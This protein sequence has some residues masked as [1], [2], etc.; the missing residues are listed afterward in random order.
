MRL[1]ARIA[2]Q[3]CLTLCFGW[4][5][6]LPGYAETG[7]AN[8]AMYLDALRAISEYRHEE[9]KAILMQLIEREPQHA[10]AWLDLAIIHCEL[11]NK[12]EAERLFR[13]MI[14]RFSPPQ[15]ILEVIAK[16]QA[17]GCAGHVREKYASVLIERGY[18]SNV[19]QGPSN[20]NFSLDSGSTRVELQLL[21][22]Y[23]P[24]AD[25]FTA[26]SMNGAR[27]LNSNGTSGFVQF[28]LRHY[29][30]L[31]AFNTVAVAAGIDRPWWIYG[32]GVRTTGM[33]SLLT[34]G[35]Q[36]YQ[37]QGIIQLRLTPSLALPNN[38]RLSVIGGLTKV[39]YPTL[40]NY[41]AS[42]WELRSLLSYDSDVFH[43]QGSVG[44]LSDRA[45]AARP[46]GHRHGFIGNASIRRQLFRQYE[47]ELKWSRQIWQ[48]ESAYSPGLID[49][50]RR[51]DIQ[52]LRATLIWP[53]RNLQT[54]RLEFRATNNRENISI[55]EY[56]SK[57][58]Q[59]SWQWQNF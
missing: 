34:L 37:K 53:V 8:Q 22:E 12:E 33:V 39:Q 44:Y 29:D 59:L 52:V 19:N 25:S 36:L 20:P 7:D 6:C 24:K 54:M 15:P 3:L 2:R 55:L 31:S 17:Q 16:Q 26:L 49:L 56:D 45:I 40:S 21:P 48:N 46:G 23:L 14:E 30:A 9:A 5:A 4:A 58:I 18:E 28:R 38:M 27:G 32:W 11:E 57:S 50:T 51:Q 35:D 10:G 42:T 43:A 41:D 1:A 47:A 13:I